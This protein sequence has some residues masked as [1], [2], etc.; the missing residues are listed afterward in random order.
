MS[1]NPI[2]TPEQAIWAL[3]RQRVYGDGD[4]QG[5]TA[6]G[7]SR[8]EHTS[9]YLRRHA[10][11]HALLAGELTDLLEDPEF[12]V[13]ADS[14]ALGDVLA[15]ATGPDH[16][17]P[18]ELAYRASYPAHRGVHPD[19]RRQILLIDA[20]RLGQRELANRLHHGDSRAVRW[21]TG[22]GRSAQLRHCLM[23][24]ETDHAP[25]AV[26][27]RASGTVDGRTVVVTT[28]PRATGG[29]E[30]VVWD[31][32]S[33]RV[34]TE[35]GRSDSP[36]GSGA[37]PVRPEPTCAT[38]ATVADGTL[39]VMG[40]D[41]GTVHAWNARTGQPRD[42]YGF[43]VHP[44]GAGRVAGVTALAVVSGGARGSR[45]VTGGRDGAVRIW[46]AADP[47][48]TGMISG[49]E[50]AHLGGVS[51]LAAVPRGLSRQDDGASWQIVSGGVDG[52]VR[53]W[54]LSPVD[55]VGPL[56]KIRG[57][58]G[59]T[60]LGLSRVPGTR[61]PVCLAGGEDGSVTLL[62]LRYGTSQPPVM[63]DGHG[64]VDVV[65][66]RDRPHA[67]TGNRDGMVTVWDLLSGEAV[68]RFPG[69][70][71][72][73]TTVT[74]VELAG[75]PHVV[76]GS[77]DGAVRVWDLEPSPSATDDPGTRGG[78]GRVQA[79]SLSPDGRLIAA[80]DLAG[81]VVVR[82]LADGSPS[83]D[84]VPVEVAAGGCSPALGWIA[85][86]GPVVAAA[87][88]DALT[89][90]GPL[91]ADQAG[92]GPAR[93]F[94]RHGLNAVAVNGSAG[95][96]LVATSSA[97]DPL[98]IWSPDDERLWVAPAH[99][100]APGEP[101]QALALAAPDRHL[102]AGVTQ[103]GR[104]LLW[105][106]SRDWAVRFRGELPGAVSVA[107]GQVRSGTGDVSWCLAAGLDSGAVVLWFLD[108]QQLDDRFLDGRPPGGPGAVS[109]D[110][111]LEIIRCPDPVRALAVTPDGSIVIA[112]G[113]D[114]VTLERR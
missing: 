25:G 87:A 58:P 82:H 78:L 42:G 49:Y 53:T 9:A 63:T 8:W 41:D 61:E 15:Q 106:Y 113:P 23:P 100:L 64:A 4:A 22:S 1:E 104:V 31:L 105:D 35:V 86:E 44:A 29:P 32:A 70:G 73:L 50:E 5:R 40:Y 54:G 51:V 96:A 30:A 98:R 46:D 56:T 107:L 62:D 11:R 99:L 83:E 94:R 39:V 38:I 71:E 76:S 34:L 95:R 112:Q 48:A 108:D 28:Y 12:L 91:A 26:A 72:G 57:G 77:S 60:A 109:D 75:R 67:V 55:A 43:P 114:L 88:E 37:G 18:A 110:K 24:A 74:V 89:I 6:D 111:Q 13:H 17:R 84:A 33:G 65:L 81:A 10:A 36:A 7:K 20:A 47:A 90:H 93:V 2:G 68:R 66:W 21:T 92:P 85:G 14:G 19:A 101:L 97:A 27:V 59:V 103:R 102:V 80:V 69:H 79:I 3:L 16:D 52:V 45:L